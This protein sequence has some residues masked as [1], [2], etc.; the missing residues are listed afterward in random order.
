VRVGLAGR[1]PARVDADLVDDRLGDLVVAKSA[2][3]SLE[4]LRTVI[5]LAGDRA[6]TWPT[7]RLPAAC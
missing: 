2:A 5:C 3:E 7:A 6:S 4:P 1:D